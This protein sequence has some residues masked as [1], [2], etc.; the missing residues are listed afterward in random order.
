[1]V[2]ASRAGASAELGVDFGHIATK[3]TSVLVPTKRIGAVGIGVSRVEAPGAT[4]IALPVAADDTIMVDSD[5]AGPIA[6]CLILGFF[7]LLVRGKQAFRPLRLAVVR[8]SI[9][10]HT[11]PQ[12]GKVHFGYIYGFGGFGCV[13]LYAIF[14]LMSDGSHSL[15]LAR[16]FSVLGYGLLPIVGLAGLAIVISLRN[17]LGARCSTCERRSQLHM[18]PPPPHI[19]QVLC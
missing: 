19:A 17:L 12:A 4:P 8:S 9:A 16:T 14:T 11:P 3:V 18:P 5:M 10:S 15:D 1:M 6:F 13:S 7:L 2:A